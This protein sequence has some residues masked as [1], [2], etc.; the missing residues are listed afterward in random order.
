MYASSSSATSGAIRCRRISHCRA[1]SA[2]NRRRSSSASR[3]Q[4]SWVG[5]AEPVDDRPP[6]DPVAA[7]RRHLVTEQRGEPVGGERSGGH[8]VTQ[9]VDCCSTCRRGS[10]PCRL[11]ITTLRLAAPGSPSSVTAVST[12]VRPVPT[13][14][15]VASRGQQ[16]QRAQVPWVATGARARRGGRRRPRPGCAARGC[17]RP[18]PRSPPWSRC[19]RSA[20]RSPPRPGPCRRPVRPG[21]R[22]GGRPPRR[23]GPGGRRR[24]PAAAGTPGRPRPGRSAAPSRSGPAG[25]SGNALMCRD[26]TLS[27]CSGS[28]VP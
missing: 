26:R 9:A 18:V 28:F 8:F 23:A 14:T 1:C 3:R 11:T 27:R 21:S 4:M 22:A 15:T 20:P 24:S 17:R 12:A 10:S 6:A 7:G 25:A 2:R 19:A 5:A 13:T 16:P